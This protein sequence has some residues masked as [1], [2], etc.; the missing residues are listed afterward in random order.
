MAL[1]LM[2][3]FEAAP[4]SQRR[5]GS[6]WLGAW[7][8]PEASTDALDVLCV[9]EPGELGERFGSE[10]PERNV[11]AWILSLLCDSAV[12]PVRVYSDGHY[13]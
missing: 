9:G 3:G 13:A 10:L 1:T 4:G 2:I 5:A 11:D 6:A 7:K 8:A 12:P